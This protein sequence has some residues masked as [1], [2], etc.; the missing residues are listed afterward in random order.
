MVVGSDKEAAVIRA[1]LSWVHPEAVGAGR[2]TAL[3]ALVGRVD[4]PRAAQRLG[5]EG[6]IQPQ[7]GLQ[8]VGSDVGK[9]LHSLGH[10][11]RQHAPRLDMD[12]V[13]RVGLH[14]AAST[15]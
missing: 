6:V 15:R 3:Q 4:R 9:D 14:R 5:I 11:A 8:I 2:N 7:V 10:A 13:N 12:L 1:E